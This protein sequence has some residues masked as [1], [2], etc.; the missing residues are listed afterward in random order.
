MRKFSLTIQL[1]SRAH[2]PDFATQLTL[3][4]VCREVPS[5]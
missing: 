3:L 5:S 1:R 4:P 2:G